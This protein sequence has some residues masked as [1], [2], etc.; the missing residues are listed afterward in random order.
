[1]IL[2]IPTQKRTHAMSPT[3][4]KTPQR[5]DLSPWYKLNQALASAKEVGS[6]FSHTMAFLAEI[7]EVKNGLLGLLDGQ[8]GKIVVEEASGPALQRAKGNKS[9][10]DEGACGEVIRLGSA[11][12]IADPASEPLLRG[13]AEDGRPAALSCICAPLRW[14]DIPLGILL[15]DDPHPQSDDGLTLLKAV[16]SFISPALVVARWGDEKSLNE[17]LRRKL[18]R[19]IARM[20]LHTES[21][22]SLMS[23]VISLVE[24]TLILTALKKAKNVQLTAARFLGINRNTLHKKIKELKI[25]LP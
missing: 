20:D 9:K 24:R 19:A 10:A 21:H 6:I 16:A 25:S 3:Q 2:F 8:R 1:M 5:P 23:D 17:I 4:G 14:G 12:V 22:G 15:I 7:S 11:A 13:M 18:E